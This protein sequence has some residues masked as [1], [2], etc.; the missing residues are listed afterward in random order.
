M[1]QGSRSAVTIGASAGRLCTCATATVDVPR[2]VSPMTRAN[3]RPRAERRI[4]TSTSGRGRGCTRVL[5]QMLVHQI[6]EFVVHRVGFGLAAFAD[7]VGRTVLEVVAHQFAAHRAQR[8]LHRGNLCE[9][10]GTIT[11]LG[12]H[13][14]ETAYLPFDAPQ[15]RLC[16]I[17]HIV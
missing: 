10:I 17:L 12:D 7:G 14:L 8:F 3:P 15:A 16:A 13:F 9:H 4:T 1:Y 11:V 2:P 5:P 6:D